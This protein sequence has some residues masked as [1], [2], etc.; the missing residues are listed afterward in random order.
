MGKFAKLG[1]NFKEGDILTIKDEGTEEEGTFGIQVVF[2]VEGGAIVA[3]EP[4]K[5]SFNKTSRNKLIDAYGEDTAKWIGKEVKV[6]VLTENVAGTM[7][8]VVYLTSPDQELVEDKD[9]AF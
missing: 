9:I 1:E 3:G 6:W 5:L 4:V 8:K 7:R 2:Q